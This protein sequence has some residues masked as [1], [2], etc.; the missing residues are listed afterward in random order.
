VTLLVVLYVVLMSLSRM[1]AGVHFPQDVIAGVVIGL[2]LLGVYAWL[3]RPI[4]VW[5]NRQKLW[6]QMGVVVVVAI[7]MLIVHPFSI[8]PNSIGGLEYAV[9]A[10]SVFFGGGIG[11]ALET[12]YLRF[13]A[14]G[15][16]WKRAVRL[17]L[18]VALITGLRF[19]LKDLFDGLEPASLF[20]IIRYSLIG[21]FAAFG[22]P[23]L[24]VRIGL[25]K[26]KL[27]SE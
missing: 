26:A 2:I 19:G 21:F 8:R 15:V 7:I 22:A 24:F 10:A 13:S 16:W 20:R 18:G 14:R 12:H 23:W 27:G 3:E 1:V 9:A 17:L 4:S 11:F 5:I 25:A 6:M